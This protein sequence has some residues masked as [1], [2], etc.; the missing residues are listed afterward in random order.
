MNLFTIIVIG[1]K[2]KPAAA[3]GTYFKSCVVSSTMG[4]GIAVNT[5][6]Y[7]V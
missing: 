2:A 3:K 1:T 7:G 6:K 4:V 5:A